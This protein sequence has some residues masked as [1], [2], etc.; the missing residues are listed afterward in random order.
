MPQPSQSSP[1]WRLALDTGG[2]FT[3]CVATAPD[4]SRH[5]A[6]VLSSAVLRARIV[7]ASG[8]AAKLDPAPP[9]R[10]A[11]GMLLRPVGALSP[12]G[13]VIDCD[14]PEVRI[15]AQQASAAG[16]ESPALRAA[17]MP[18]PG[19]LVELFADEEAPILAARVLTGT[20]AGEP[21]PPMAMRLATTRGTNALLERS[22]A[23][24]GLAITR[25]FGDLPFIRDQR[26]RDL[27]ALRIERPPPL[28]ET[29]VEVEERIAADGGVLEPLTRHEIDRV[30]TALHGVD[31]V[32]IALLH[33][34]IRPDHEEQLAAALR[35]A[36]HTQVW[37]S[38][39][40]HAG[41]GFLR[42][43]EGALIDAALGPVVA[44]YLARVR[45]GFDG[46]DRGKT[47]PAPRTGV[48]GASGSGATG[49]SRLLVMTSAGGLVDSANFRPSDGLLSGPAGG[50]A[51]AALAAR[52]GAPGRFARA[53]A[54]DMGGTSTDVCRIEGEPILRHAHR[55]GE[56]EIAA[57][58]VAIETV[59]AGGGS[60]LGFDGVLFTV[61]PRS[62]GADPG[63]A[64]HG[65]GGPLTLADADLLLGRMDPSRMGIPI[66]RAAALRAAETL[67]ATAA[68]ALAAEE[69]AGSAPART[70]HDGA[71]GPASAPATTGPD[72]SAEDSAAIRPS[73]RTARMLQRL[74]DLADER[75]AEAIAS[76]SIRQGIDCADHV[77]I[78]FGGSG[79]IHACAVA[80]R[81]GISTVLLPADAG[82]LSAV[83]LDAAP[84]QRRASSAVHRRL[85]ESALIAL[86]GAADG[87]LDDALAALA[88]DLGG[89]APDDS[90]RARCIA[91][92][93][94][95]LRSLG[96]ESALDTAFDRDDSPSAI[97]ER[98]RRAYARLH[99]TQ[100]PDR[101]IEIVD[102]HVSASLDERATRGTVPG[103]APAA[104]AAASPAARSAEPTAS[105]TTLAAWFDG[106]WRR[107]A[108]VDVERLTALRRG[109][110]PVRAPCARDESRRG[111]RHDRVAEGAE[112]DGA[113]GRALEAGP[114]L[115]GPLLVR[116]A[117]G[118]AWIPPGWRVEPEDAAG[119][120]GGLLLRRSAERGPVAV[121]TPREIVAARLTSIAESMGELL[122]RTA[123]SVN[124]K[125]RLDFSC[126]LLDARG[127]LVVNAAHVPVH[128]GALGPCVRAVAAALRAARPPRRGDVWLSNHPECGGSHLPDLTVITPIFAAGTETE[129]I[130]FAASRAHHAELGGIRPGSMPFDARSLAEEA[131]VVT[132]FL[133]AEAGGARWDEL[134]ALLSAA[135]WPSRAVAEN[136]ADLR[137]AVAANALGA[138]QLSALAAAIGP[139]ALSER[140]DEMRAHARTLARRAVTR[141]AAGEGAVAAPRTAADRLDDGTPIV[142]TIER[143]GG[144]L[145]I[146]FT[147]SG[148][149]LSG[150]L[151]ATPAIVRAVTMYVLR[152]LIDEPGALALPLN[153]G[154]LE[155]VSI[156]VPPGLLRPFFVADPARSPPVGAGNTEISQR[157]ADLLLRAAGA[158]AGSQATM[159]N[160][161]FGAAAGPAF[162]CYET[163]GGG[164]GAVPGLGAEASAAGVAGAGG[165][166]GA[167]G[168][169]VHMTNTRITDVE[170][171]E[172]RWPVRIER[173]ALRRGSGGAGRRRGGDGLLRAY[174][175]LAPVS[176]SI[177]SQRRTLGAPGLGAGEPGAPGRNTLFHVDG[178][179][180]DLGSCA[181]LDVE[182]GA[183]LL[184]ETPGGGGWA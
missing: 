29:I 87:A 48:P 59:A 174:R 50:A 10:A 35:A 148:P 117:H 69:P 49:A 60:V 43:M 129:P 85:D 74:V 11:L 17:A 22:T 136:L 56:V 142:A 158:Q 102:V 157:L 41:L 76:I 116:Q 181:A 103:S 91:T 70:D 163:L 171:L 151:N 121:A 177:L 53:L 166:D 118:S 135:P 127:R 152:T 173:F 180:I 149:V 150:P 66:D 38:A 62:A 107:A 106:T 165:A 110:E 156:H 169:H 182:A 137:A 113:E 170:V 123:I 7:A 75:M 164:A 122:R 37:T 73:R 2:T 25:G 104:A 3:D 72:P 21:L 33:S 111:D 51:G 172:R 143:R 68:A 57:P 61:G 6:K 124:V 132:P 108:I 100:P 130:G 8:A 47:D 176:L 159:N 125:E 115:E 4:G 20:P 162:G 15:A 128:L 79:G 24:C 134:E 161:I 93:S 131:V 160:V 19:S 144:R 31:A 98:F 168:V 141:L 55:V 58:A 94:A 147:G 179:S 155:D 44:T 154:L 114:P 89:G 99:G 97:A 83:G 77:L 140:L 81:L 175:F 71:R 95:E 86:R 65:R 46:A 145:R 36:G 52:A 184:I 42:R 84:L 18:A 63:P 39:T 167:G 40:A 16:A 12:I 30:V 133:L 105:V 146:D 1:I 139:A 5:R 32:A 26:R 92:C 82:L 78:A 101:P 67:A 138:E 126:G 112:R 120:S 28:A 178:R 14:G 54:F 153:E 23:R 80:D 64:F 27:F 88:R 45:R 109:D 90:L 96:Q 119:S 13:T 183:L 9:S 34:W